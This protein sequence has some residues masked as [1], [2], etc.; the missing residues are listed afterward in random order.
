M[1]G[2]GDRFARAGGVGRFD[3]GRRQNLGKPIRAEGAGSA[4]VSLAS[5]LRTRK[6]PGP[7]LFLL[8]IPGHCRSR[9]RECQKRGEHPPFP[10]PRFRVKNNSEMSASGEGANRRSC[11]RPPTVS[12][13]RYQDG[14]FPERETGNGAPS[15]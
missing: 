15:A 14:I 9:G 12:Q 7:Y 2:K 6:Q 11:P 5:A 8:V 13:R 1:G 10:P 3:I 4:G